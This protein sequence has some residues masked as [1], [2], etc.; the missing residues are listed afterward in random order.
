MSGRREFR[1]GKSDKTDSAETHKV[2]I[3]RRNTKLRGLNENSESE[4]QVRQ[5]PGE[6]D[7]NRG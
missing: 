4:E 5:N 1:R 6:V 3:K 2:I 7:R